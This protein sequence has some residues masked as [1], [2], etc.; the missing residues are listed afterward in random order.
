MMW[1]TPKDLK[2]QLARLWDRG[3]LLRDAV[4]GNTRFPLRLTIKGPASADITERFDAVRTWAAG[5]ANASPLRLEWQ[6]IRHRVQGF[7]R[8][9]SGGW[10][11]SMDDALRWLGKRREWDRFS[12]LVEM[13]RL[14]N[15][16]L[17]PWLE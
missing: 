11:D 2:A 9:P 16:S 1:T 12:N 14:Q 7:Q 8:L 6:E 4:A 5:L 10:I 15:P 17:M 13:T 3:E